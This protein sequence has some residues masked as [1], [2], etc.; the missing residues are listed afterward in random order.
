MIP[1]A[2]VE[3]MC[4]SMCR[5]P[6]VLRC[7]HATHNKRRCGRTAVPDLMKELLLEPEGSVAGKGNR[8]AVV[9]GNSPAA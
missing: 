7:S 5:C 1:R 9:L 6:R 2:Q 8:K 3:S 4:S